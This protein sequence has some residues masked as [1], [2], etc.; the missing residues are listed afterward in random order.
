MNSAL[1]GIEEL[2]TKYRDRPMDRCTNG[3][4]KGAKLRLKIAPGARVLTGRH[5]RDAIAA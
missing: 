1:P 4:R 3:S 2:M 5:L